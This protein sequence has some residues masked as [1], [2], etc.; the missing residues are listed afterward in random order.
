MDIIK[1]L[2]FHL[3]LVTY[4]PTQTYYLSYIWSVCIW[5]P[6]LNIII[7]CGYCG[8]ASLYGDWALFIIIMRFHHGNLEEWWSQN[9]A[10]VLSNNTR[11]LIWY[12]SRA[13][14]FSWLYLQT[15]IVPPCLCLVF[16]QNQNS[17]EDYI[18]CHIGE[19]F[20][21]YVTPPYRLYEAMSKAIFLR[22]APDSWLTVRNVLKKRIIHI[23]FSLFNYCFHPK[24]FKA[25]III[26]N[27]LFKLQWSHTYCECWCLCVT[28]WYRCQ[29]I[30]LALLQL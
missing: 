9:C 28:P 22:I 13:M 12:S 2:G 6:N 8:L 23:T 16:K 14:C 30:P 29:H 15:H 27:L 11:L 19:Y 7:Q 5:S 4:C 17:L 18:H 21:G 20:Q 3:A 25:K 24:H 26:H 10:E 1:V